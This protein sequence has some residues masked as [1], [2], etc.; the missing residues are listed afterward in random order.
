MLFVWIDSGAKKSVPVSRII[1]TI[2]G[3]TPLLAASF[4]ILGEMI[5]TMGEKYSRLPSKWCTYFLLTL[6]SEYS[7]NFPMQ[8]LDCSSLAYVD[9]SSKHPPFV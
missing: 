1:C 7:F 5:K 9:C 3:P 8:I 4:M 2:I 6:R